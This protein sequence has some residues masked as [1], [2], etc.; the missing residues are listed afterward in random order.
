MWRPADVLSPDAP[1]QP[2]DILAWRGTGFVPSVIRA[3]TLSDWHHVAVV[4]PPESPGGPL[5]V[6]EAAPGKGVQ[7]VPLDTVRP[8]YRIP[9]RGRFT[10]S[11]FVTASGWLGAS[12]SLT[13]CLLS[14]VRLRPIMPGYHCA[15]L[16]RE[17]LRLVG[18]DVVD[19]SP[20]PDDVVLA[21][22]RQGKSLV[23]LP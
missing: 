19:A 13:D 12:Y 9:M 14:W 3:L 15:E 10:M 7:M 17:W 22:L 11:A 23:Y 8:A 1:V 16:A 6:L 20:T 2:G 18:L 5:R 21:L 4:V